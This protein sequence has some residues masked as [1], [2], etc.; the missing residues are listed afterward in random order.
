MKQRV[1][2]F[3]LTLTLMFTAFPVSARAESSE[4]E[5]KAVY[6]TP[7]SDYKSGDCI[8]TATKMMIRRSMIMSGKGDWNKVTNKKLRKSAT[9]FGLLLNSFKYDSEGTVFWVDSGS[10]TGKSDKARI[11]EIENL[12]REHPEGIVVHGTNA[13]STGTHGVLA[14]KVEDGVIFAADS[15]RN[16]GLNNK[17]IQKWKRTTMLNPGKVTKY[18]YIS[19]TWASA[20]T[21]PSKLSNGA[22]VSALCIKSVRAPSKIKVQNSFSIK[23]VVKSDETI[24]KVRVRVLNSKGKTVIS[25]TR[26]PDSNSFDLKEVDARIKFGTLKKG[27]YTYQVIATDNVQTLKLVNKQFRVVK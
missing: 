24:T 3:I 12:L 5:D 19:G 4:I 25:A 2:V 9:I 7:A 23:G 14:V 20:K 18:W 6:Y 1:T 17:G 26:R 27:K 21:A 13:A 16:T 15:S 11:K 10:F 22:A 8:L